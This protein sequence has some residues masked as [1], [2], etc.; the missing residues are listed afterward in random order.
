MLEPGMVRFQ[1]NHFDLLD[2]GWSR[3]LNLVVPSPTD[4]ERKEGQHRDIGLI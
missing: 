3:N 2:S 1:I 4:I